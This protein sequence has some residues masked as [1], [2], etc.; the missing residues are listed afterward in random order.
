MKKE[1]YEKLREELEEEMVFMECG[2]NK[3]RTVK[4]IEREALFR[5]LRRHLEDEKQL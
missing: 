4:A 3:E 1:E 2:V 5:A